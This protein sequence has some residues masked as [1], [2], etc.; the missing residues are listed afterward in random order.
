MFSAL[1]DLWIKV[2][3]TVREKAS[4][5]PVVASG[6]WESTGCRRRKKYVKSFNELLDIFKSEFY[7]TNIGPDTI[8]A[9]TT[10]E[11]DN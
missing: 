10:P 9:K 7:F 1:L 6:P 8:F 11:N 4:P 3:Q 2:D 5:R